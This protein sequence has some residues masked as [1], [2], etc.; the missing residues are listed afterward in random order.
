MAQTLFG[1]Q[2]VIH[3]YNFRAYMSESVC[4]YIYM[5]EMWTYLWPFDSGLPLEKIRQNLTRQ[6]ALDVNLS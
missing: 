4:V 3:T 2:F 6:V 1:L 5:S